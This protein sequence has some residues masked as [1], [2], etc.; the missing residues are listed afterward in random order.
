MAGKSPPF[1][2]FKIRKQKCR[3]MI[4][5]LSRGSR[6]FPAVWTPCPHSAA[7]F[8]RVGSPV[9]ARIWPI[10]ICAFR[11]IVKIGVR[12]HSI[13]DRVSSVNTK[14]GQAGLTCFLKST[15]RSGQNAR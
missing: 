1:S 15:D 7:E 3:G 14:L 10:K 8:C 11:E 13:I 6:R 12:G 5:L 4:T 9:R 2:N